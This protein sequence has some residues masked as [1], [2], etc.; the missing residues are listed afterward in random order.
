MQE[1]FK[2]VSVEPSEAPDDLDGANWYCYIIGRGTNRIRGYRQGNLTS[3]TESLEEIVVNLNERRK[4]RYLHFPPRTSRGQKPA[5]TDREVGPAVTAG[6]SGDQA[7]AG[8]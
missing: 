6:G 5:G 2:I 7:A 4:G 3:I 1:A 8:K